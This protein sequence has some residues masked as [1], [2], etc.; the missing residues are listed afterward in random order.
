MSYD[1]QAQS[2][3]ILNKQLYMITTSTMKYYRRV[4]HVI[5]SDELQKT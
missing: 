1:K 2:C 4:E 5:P 3:V